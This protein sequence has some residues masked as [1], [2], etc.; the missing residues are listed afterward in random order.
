[1]KFCEE[2]GLL[3]A[4]VVLTQIVEGESRTFHL[5]EECAANRGIRVSSDEA[6]V[7]SAPADGQTPSAA[8][9]G[10]RDCPSCG[11][12][13]SAFRAGGRL[14]C[15]SCYEAFRQEVDALLIQMHGACLYRGKRFRDCS[16]AASPGNDVARLKA[17]LDEA[18]RSEDFERAALIRD[19]IHEKENAPDS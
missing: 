5:C 2:C 17:E 6:A 4:N 11:K 1:M 10:D 18:I 8:A 14:G 16:A 9:A 15:P 12:K 7:T 3:P 13:L 19:S